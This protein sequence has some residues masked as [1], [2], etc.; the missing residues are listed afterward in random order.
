MPHSDLAK[1]DQVVIQCPACGASEAADA[2]LLADAP[3]IVCRNCGETWPT[4][5]PRA[6]SRP[7]MRPRRAVSVSR[8]NVD[9]Q[10]VPLVTYAGEMDRAWAAKVAGDVLPGVAPRRSRIPGATAALASLL[11]IAAFL[12]GREAA[13]A[14]LPDLAALYGSLGMPVN[15][16]GLEIRG[17]GA[18]RAPSQT[19]GRVSVRGEIVNVSRTELRIPP[20]D[21]SFHDASMMPAG[22]RGF[23]P[24][25]HILAA[26]DG[27]AFTL[28]LEGVP[29]GA[30]RIVLRFRRP[31]EP[32]PSQGA[33][34]GA[35]QGREASR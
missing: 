11:F 10:R 23:D 32:T 8:N 34:Q 27:A 9:A 6:G 21:V 31:G 12:G 7:S 25:A 2:T 14:A 29:Q 17:I 19:A 5:G 35:S 24:P 20:L 26:G 15:L 1:S 13:V 16:D 18:D 4:T 3:M 28:Q 33:S 22:S 30:S